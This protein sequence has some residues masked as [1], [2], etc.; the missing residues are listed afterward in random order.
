MAFLAPLVPMIMGA[1]A[2]IGGAAAAV[3]PIA[4]VAS[5]GVGAYSM[6]NQPKTSA[7]QVSSP[8]APASFAQ[9]YAAEQNKL[10]SATQ[11]Q[12]QTILTSPLGLA[13]DPSKTK[14][15]LLLGN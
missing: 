12:T 13:D 2:A 7:L 10:L 6:M 11:K 8:E 9:T 15:K 4:T 3:A 1:G 14:R 5:I